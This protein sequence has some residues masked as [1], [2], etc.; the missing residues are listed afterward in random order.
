MTNG[1]LFV[2]CYVKLFFAICL[3]LIFSVSH[4]VEI[5]SQQV[6]A[7]NL[8]QPV[9][10]AEKSIF[11]DAQ[12]LHFESAIVEN[13]ST[14][15]SVFAYKNEIWTANPIKRELSRFDNS[16][17]LTKK[18]DVSQTAESKNQPEP[19]AIA[20]YEDVI[21]WAD[22]ANH[23]ICRFDLVKN[24]PLSCFGERGEMDGQFQYPY[25]MAFDRDGYLYVVDIMNSRIQQFDKKHF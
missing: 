2:K 15:L 1:L 18:I 20:V 9:G 4:A 5:T 8:A 3:W 14:A 24:A 6:L 12:G 25:Q 10:V 11:L 13:E 23:R 19:I 16:G 7:A 17:K 22:R 21:Y